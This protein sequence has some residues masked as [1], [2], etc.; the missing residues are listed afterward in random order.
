[1]KVWP[2]KVLRR[3]R[4]DEL[5]AAEAT[6]EVDAQE[7]TDIATERDAL[8]AKQLM[9]EQEL[10]VLRRKARHADEDT[11][12]VVVRAA[13]ALFNLRLAQ[14]R[15]DDLA[16]QAQV[17]IL[18]RSLAIELLHEIDHSQLPPEAAEQIRIAIDALVRGGEVVK[19]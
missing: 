14:Q 16:D 18:R 1:M 6:G 15:I 3:D 2:I 10:K 19:A 7:A 4:Y 11:L 9:Q 5:V 13:A 12:A 8:A 17:L